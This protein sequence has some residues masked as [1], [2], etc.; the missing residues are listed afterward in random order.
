MLSA[1]EIARGVTGAL[2]F[3][4]RDAAAPYYFENSR[5][6][7]LRSFRVMALVAPV[8]ALRRLLDYGGVDVGAEPDEILIV[9]ILYYVVGWL[10]FPVVFYEIARRRRWL[11]R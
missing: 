6:A 3:L 11:D 2:R 10:L 8:Y 1:S 9:E 5:E 7:C 4:Q